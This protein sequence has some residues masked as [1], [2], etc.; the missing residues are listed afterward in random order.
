MADARRLGS[1]GAAA[2]CACA[3]LGSA[4]LVFGQRTSFHD[5]DTALLAIMAKQRLTWFYWDQNRF[6][7]LV[8]FATAWIAPIRLNLAAQLWLGSVAGFAS[9]GFAMELAGI[10]TRRVEAFAVTVIVLMTCM[11]P[12][13]VGGFF[14]GPV[15]YPVSCAMC[16]LGLRA[17]RAEGGGAAALALSAVLFWLAFFVNAA[18]A[19]FV[20]PVLA[21]GC[22]RPGRR[23]R[24]TLAMALLGTV[25]AAALSLLSG[26][27][28]PSA[29]APG[30]DPLRAALTAMAG[31]FDATWLLAAA[32]A[33]AAIALAAGRGV[34][35]PLALRSQTAA[36]VW[37]MLASACLYASLQWVQLNGNLA[38]YYFVQV[39]TAATLVACWMSETLLA[40]LP[41]MTRRGR[42]LLQHGLLAAAFASIA[43]A[44][45]GVHSLRF[46]SAVQGRELA[47]N[48]DMKAI[49][50]QV[51]GDRPAVVVGD[52]WLAVPIV[53]A[54]L[55]RAAAPPI[56]ALTSHWQ[57]MRPE[58]QR[59]LA[60]SQP[61]T[62]IC[63]QVPLANCVEQL[64]GWGGLPSHGRQHAVAA[65]AG[66][67]SGGTYI[68]ATSRP[69]G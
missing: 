67:A 49:A 58:L 57:V 4:A 55:D 2:V 5:A 28:T 69:G 34:G 52:Y 20:L 31:Q 37:A 50:R 38:R 46:V 11:R 65:E 44:A 36:V 54:L 32:S 41:Q 68:V 33:V 59:V 8:P 42:A 66:L 7:N 22:L 35:A 56:F 63:V 17:A 18:L 14:T 64:E 16:Y 26:P 21:L 23:P 12:E 6:G 45:G 40:T 13:F 48:A 27:G 47:I 60:S 29:V 62:L 53:F 24:L 43:W 61:V 3:A 1:R 15:P 30:G 39:F 9:I 51:P 10:R 25:A 19:A